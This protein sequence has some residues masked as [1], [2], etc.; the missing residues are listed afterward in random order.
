EIGSWLCKKIRGSE[1]EHMIAHHRSED[2]WLHAGASASADA[3][4]SASA[5]ASTSASTSASASA[6]TSATASATA[7]AS[8]SAGATA[9]ARVAASDAG[10]V[11]VKKTGRC[12]LCGAVV[13]QKNLLR[14]ARKHY[15]KQHLCV[16]GVMF[17][18]L[19]ALA[20]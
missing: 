15:G 9:T 1:P 19:D 10:P 18:R 16:C 3:S 5:S 12:V 14:H 4:A 17:V 8:A 13:L 7:S 20:K 6:T 11:D 2:A